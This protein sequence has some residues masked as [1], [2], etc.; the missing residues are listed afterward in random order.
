MFA[1]LRGRDITFTSL[2]LLIGV[3]LLSA[4]WFGAR[5]FQKQMLQEQAQSEALHWATYLERH[6]NDLDGLLSDGWLTEEDQEVLDFVIEGGH[7]AARLMK[8]G[9]RS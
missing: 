8:A 3:L 6:L 7:S 4:G 9:P 5:E 1:N 2:L